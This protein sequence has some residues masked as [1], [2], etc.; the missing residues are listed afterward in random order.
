MTAYEQGFTEKC[1]ELGIDPKELLKAAGFWDSVGKGVSKGMRT[2]GDFMDRHP[3]Y[4]TIATTGMYPLMKGAR[5]FSRWVRGVK[6]D[7]VAPPS[8]IPGVPAGVGA[9]ALYNPAAMQG[10]RQGMQPA[11]HP[12]M[13]AMVR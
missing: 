12:G 11:L 2:V 1:A 3:I 7:K 4:S 13:A 5:R 8:G 6:G 9:P 10:M